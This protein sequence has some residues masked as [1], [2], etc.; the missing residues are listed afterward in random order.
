MEREKRV[1]SILKFNVIYV[2]YVSFI[3]MKYSELL[4]CRH[5]GSYFQ[6]PKWKRDEKN[7]DQEQ[8]SHL[9]VV[10]EFNEGLMLA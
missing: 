1:W 8:R 7:Q 9:I 3:S 2:I 4:I 5:F 6:T 10:R